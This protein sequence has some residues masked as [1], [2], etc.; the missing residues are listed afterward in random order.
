[1]KKSHIILGVMSILGLASFLIP[2]FLP[3]SSLNPNKGMFTWGLFVSAVMLFSI[4][5]FLLEF[6]RITM[7]SKEIG[8]IAI[9]GAVSAV[10]RVPFAVIPSVQPCTYLII[11]TGY[12]FGPIAGFMVGAITAL[13]SNLFLG[14]GPWTLYQIFAWGLAGFA[15]GFIK[16]NKTWKLCLYGFIHGYLFG[17][18]TNIWFWS[19]F[20]YPL[21]FRTLLAIQINS[22][23]FDTFHALGNV[24]FLWIFGLKTIKIFERYKKRFHVE[25][26]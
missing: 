5:A 21:N 1:M 3:D 19:A 13:I 14:M 23:W 10:S 12:V 9:L 18:I 8:F 7:S 11:C 24:I 15:A 4:A 20:I 26:L 6:E 25:R 2:I 17:L 16:L 22:F